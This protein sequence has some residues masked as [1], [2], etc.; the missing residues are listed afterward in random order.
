MTRPTFGAL[1]LLLGLAACTDNDAIGNDRA[2][3]L[4]PP[5][6]PAERA[7]AESLAQVEPG[8]L[9]PA[10]FTEADIASL[11]LP[12][13]SCLFRYTDAGF[14]VFLYPAGGDAPAI[15]KL[16]GKLIMLPP[17]G[18]FHYAAGPIRVEMSHPD[19]VPT[20]G[21]EEAVL[22]LR[23]AGASDELGFLGVTE[24]P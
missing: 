14:P 15:I 23:L 12:R 13:A 6:L 20:E 18:G 10:P 11:S 17:V 3:Q 24:C 4:D 9:K 22:I 2:A 7:P 21:E 8:L 1:A 19:G 16:N 5:T